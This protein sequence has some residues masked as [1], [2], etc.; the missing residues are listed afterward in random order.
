MKRIGLLR[1]A[2]KNLLRKR[3]RSLLTVFGIALAAWVLVSLFGFN[4][5]Y[6]ESL[7]T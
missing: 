5:G 1:I 7:N 6:E 2:Y 3:T 4:Q